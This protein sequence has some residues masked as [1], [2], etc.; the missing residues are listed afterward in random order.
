MDLEIMLTLK[1]EIK[2]MNIFNG[3]DFT[4][5][6]ESGSKQISLSWSVIGH[7]F[8]VFLPYMSQYL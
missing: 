5:E 7:L 2:V 4:P 1:H 3:F 6:L 8:Y